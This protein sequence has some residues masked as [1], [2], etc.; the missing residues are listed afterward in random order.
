MTGKP[1]VLQSMESQCVGHNLVT[2]QRFLLT[3]RYSELGKCVLVMVTRSVTLMVLTPCQC[4]FL[5]FPVG[6][7]WCRPA[8]METEWNQRPQQ[9][10]GA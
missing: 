2:E 4:Y 9:A 5:N 10:M 7:P 1:D 3:G 6:R 8:G